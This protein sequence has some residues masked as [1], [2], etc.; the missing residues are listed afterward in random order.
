[1]DVSNLVELK[2]IRRDSK[3]RGQGFDEDRATDLIVEA[4]ASIH[5]VLTALRR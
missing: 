1:M 2:D 5:K 3:H 4:T